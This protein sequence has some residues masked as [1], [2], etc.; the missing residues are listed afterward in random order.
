LLFLWKSQFPGEGEIADD[1]EVLKIIRLA[2]DGR[3]SPAA[4]VGGLA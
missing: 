1:A 3:S 2:L 4:E